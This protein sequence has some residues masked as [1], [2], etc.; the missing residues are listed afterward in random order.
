VPRNFA[1]EP[2]GE[3]IFAAN[4]NSGSVVLLDINQNTG[5]LQPTGRELSVNRAVCVVFVAAQ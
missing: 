3:Y 4:Q 5:E 1:I 2:T